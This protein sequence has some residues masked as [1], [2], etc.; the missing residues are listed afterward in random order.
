MLH[1]HC[2]CL[3]PKHFHQA[4]TLLKGRGQVPRRISFDLRLSDVFSQLDQDY[5]LGAR[6]ALR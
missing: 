6:K 5:A 3:V 1:S 4:L 2:F